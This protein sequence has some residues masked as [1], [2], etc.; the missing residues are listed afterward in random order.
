MIITYRKLGKGRSRVGK[1]RTEHCGLHTGDRVHEGTEEDNLD[2]RKGH[3]EGLH[4]E[5]E[6]H[7]NPNG[8]R[9]D[10]D[11]EGADQAYPHTPEAGNGASDFDTEWRPTWDQEGHKDLVDHHNLD[12]RDREALALQR[13]RQQ[14][15]A[16]LLPS[17]RRSQSP[18]WFLWNGR[19]V[20]CARR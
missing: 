1:A 9:L 2:S 4:E 11:R 7:S 19:R 17:P 6:D 5:G 12:R 3:L 13:Q 14:R 8:N 20:G 16:F 18:C 15:P 10:R